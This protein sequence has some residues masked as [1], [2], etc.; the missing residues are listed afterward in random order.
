MNLKK[1]D[2]M[3]VKDI[4]QFIWDNGACNGDDYLIIS[5]GIKLQ[6]KKLS[7]FIVFFYEL[8]DMYYIND[9]KF[10][11]SYTRKMKIEKLLKNEII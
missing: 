8:K 5:S 9:F 11:L 2:W 1:G 10:E 7:E 4:H 6:I 3:S